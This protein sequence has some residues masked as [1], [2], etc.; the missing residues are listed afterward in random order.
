LSTNNMGDSSQ[1]PIVTCLDALA[2]PYPGTE[3]V[4]DSGRYPENLEEAHVDKSD[5]SKWGGGGVGKGVIKG[6]KTRVV[7]RTDLRK[8]CDIVD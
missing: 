5:G 3:A 8:E 7:L 6:C 1:V 4:F 2:H